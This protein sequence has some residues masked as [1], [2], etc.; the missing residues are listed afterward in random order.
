[1]I[2]KTEQTYPLGG[3]SHHHR[4]FCLQL[5]ISLLFEKVTVVNRS[6]DQIPDFSH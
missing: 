2:R 3:G 4:K 5:F 6:A 1:L